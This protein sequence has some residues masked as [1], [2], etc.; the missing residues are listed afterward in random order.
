MAAVAQDR[1][2]TR[3]GRELESGGDEKERPIT[4]VTRWMR[5]SWVPIVLTIVACVSGGIITAQHSEQLAPFDEWVY[6][7]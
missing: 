3:H 5:N 2:A 1:E 6:Y 4:R 7:D